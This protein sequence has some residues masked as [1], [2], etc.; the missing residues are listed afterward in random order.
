V[1][2]ELSC[3]F[4]CRIVQISEDFPAEKTLLRNYLRNLLQNYLRYVRRNHSQAGEPP[5]LWPKGFLRILFAFHE[6]SSA[7]TFPVVFKILICLDWWFMME[8]NE[9]GWDNISFHCL[10]FKN[11]DG[12]KWNI[13][14]WIPSYSII[15]PNFSSPQFGRYGMEPLSQIWKWPIYPLLSISLIF[16]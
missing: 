13:M 9:M 3:G 16:I 1:Y 6:E 14:G 11:K 10:D 15:S 5:P 2:Q 4:F 12:M 8:W 7:G